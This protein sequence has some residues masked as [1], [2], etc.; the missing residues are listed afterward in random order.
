MSDKVGKWKKEN[1]RIT[2]MPTNVK[3]FLQF[4]LKTKVLE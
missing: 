1:I 2:L 3:K 4:G